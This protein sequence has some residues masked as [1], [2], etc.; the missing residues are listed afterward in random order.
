MCVIIIV[1][2]ITLASITIS[3]KQTNKK[4]R[5]YDILPW[6]RPHDN[7]VEHMTKQ[8][9]RIQCSTAASAMTNNFSYIT[10][11][12]NNNNDN[13]KYIHLFVTDIKIF[14]VYLFL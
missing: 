5:L 6:N 7:N 2:P 10:F 9:I 1:S 8:F 14:K 13:K 12:N 11:H 3:K 4:T